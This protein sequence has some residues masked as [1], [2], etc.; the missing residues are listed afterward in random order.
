[1]C[2]T[3]FSTLVYSTLEAVLSRRQQASWTRILRAPVSDSTAVNL[4]EKIV[5]FGGKQGGSPVSAIHQLM[6]GKWVTIGSMT[7]ERIMCLAV[8]NPL[9][10]KVLIFS[11]QGGQENA[12]NTENMDT[13][14]IVP[15]L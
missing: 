4:C 13:E 6:D 9:D 8:V 11:G 14:I 10:N 1:M 15:K 3:L 5:S 12:V 2:I 7:C